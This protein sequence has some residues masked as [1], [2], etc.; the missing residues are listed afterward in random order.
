M[1]LTVHISAIAILVLKLGKLSYLTNIN[2]IL[3]LLMYE[4]FKDMNVTVVTIIQHI[5][6]VQFRLK[7]IL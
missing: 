1:E 6:I 2:L 3:N 5:Q 7:S 4:L